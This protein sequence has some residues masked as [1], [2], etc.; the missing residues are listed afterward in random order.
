MTRVGRITSDTMSSAALSVLVVDDTSA[1]RNLMAAFL[2][3]LGHEAVFAVDGVEA[4]E[5]FGQRRPDMILMDLMMPRMDGFEATRLVR[6][7][8]GAIWT[9]IVIMSALNSDADIVA[10]LDAGADD[11]LVKPV[12]FAVFAAKMRTIQRLLEMER[13]QRE[14]LDRMHAISNAVIDGIITIDETGV[15]QSANPAACKMFG[16]ENDAL[17]GKSVSVLAAPPDGRQSDRQLANYLA[18]GTAGMIGTVRELQGERADGEVFPL[19]VGVTELQID[20]H[21]LYIG[22]MRDISERLIQHAALAENAA[23]LQRYHDEQQREQELARQIMASQVDAAGL[24]DARVHFT[25]MPARR[26]SGDL[27]VAASSPGGRLYA[28]LA[29][30]TGHGLSAAISVQPVLPVFYALVARDVPLAQLVGELNAVLHRSLP[31]GRFVGAALAC[32]NRQG[33]DVEIWVGGV[34]EM[35]LVGADGRV[36]QRFESNHLPLGVIETGTEGC[37]VAHARTLPGDQL[38]MYS[39]GVIEA[40]ND[41]A[42]GFG[43]LRLEEV[44]RAH[45]KDMRIDALRIALAEHLAGASAHDDMS[46]LMLDCAPH[47]H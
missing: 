31:I 39:D 4:L 16:Y 26:F 30:A 2:A 24:R 10:G 34:P 47:P 18:G 37:E 1:N 5:R 35:V 40:T 23:R 13:R 3:K 25:V 32:L 17:A 41:K 22:V 20:D 27:V 21:R 29:D 36:R 14:L 43:R 7:R 8:Q 11:Y 12:S 6:E 15:I 42:E 28:M 33:D 19:E 44:L 46:A 9:P 38:V 45:A